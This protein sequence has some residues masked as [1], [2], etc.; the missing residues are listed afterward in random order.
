MNELMN[1]WTWLKSLG[2]LTEDGISNISQGSYF[3]ALALLKIK[4]IDSV[5]DRLTIIASTQK[6][7]STSKYVTVVRKNIT[8]KTIA[9]LEV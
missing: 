3:W 1:E 8:V 4:S 5:I 9:I 2:M 6:I 7:V